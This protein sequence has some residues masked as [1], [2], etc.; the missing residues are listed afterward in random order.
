MYILIAILTLSALFVIQSFR[1]RRERRK[2]LALRREIVCRD[3]DAAYSKNKD[4][5][6]IR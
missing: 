3:N 2:A 1:L 5:D 4:N 6:H